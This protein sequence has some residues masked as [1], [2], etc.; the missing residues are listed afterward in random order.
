[1][2]LDDDWDPTILDNEYLPEDFPDNDEEFPNVYAD[3]RVNMYGDI[4]FDIEASGNKR[5]SSTTWST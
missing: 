1:M 4:D 2:T 5:R 3:P